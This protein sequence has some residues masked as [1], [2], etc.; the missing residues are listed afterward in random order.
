M[1]TANKSIEAPAKPVEETQAFKDA[2]AAALAAELAKRPAKPES[3]YR[4]WATKDVPSAMV[5]FAKWISREFP[6]LG[7]ELNPETG[8]ADEK[9]E[10]LVTIASKAYKYFQASD[11]NDER[12][13]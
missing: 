11:L 10:R 4:A 1:A 13:A 6:E 5:Y 12:K 3:G 7:I 8:R 2:L 9:L